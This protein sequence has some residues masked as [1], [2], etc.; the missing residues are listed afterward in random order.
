MSRE[1]LPWLLPILGPTACGGGNAFQQNTLVV[2]L[3]KRVDRLN[4]VDGSRFSADSAVTQD[5][6]GRK[7][8]Q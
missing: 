2:A 1:L 7:L 8:E 5:A 3:V 4:S 6:K